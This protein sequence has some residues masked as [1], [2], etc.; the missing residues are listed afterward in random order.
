MLVYQQADRTVFFN[1]AHNHYLQL[2]AEGGALLAVPVAVAAAALAVT[3]RRRLA[4]DALPAF[5]IRLGAT[6]S[7]VAVAVQSLWETG[8]RMP[9]NAV[10]FAIVA[11][12]AAA[13]MRGGRG[14][15]SSGTRRA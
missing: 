13:P 15:G 11:A 4:A 2:A 12:V 8:L 1:Q 14:G 10:L 9:A 7:L 6:S 3:I 5:W